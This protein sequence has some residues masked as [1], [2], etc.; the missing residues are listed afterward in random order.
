LTFQAQIFGHLEIKIDGTAVDLTPPGIPSEWTT[1]SVAVDA[2]AGQTA[3]VSFAAVGKAFDCGVGGGWTGSYVLLDQVQ[4][5]VPLPPPVLSIQPFGSTG[6]YLSLKFTGVLQSSD[7]PDSGFVD[8]P[9]AK[10]PFPIPDASVG[11]PTR[12][13]RTRQ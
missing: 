5:I 8:V 12:Y 1:Y 2:F 6:Q 3:T 4:F 9:E 13:F 10:S 7:R 11:G